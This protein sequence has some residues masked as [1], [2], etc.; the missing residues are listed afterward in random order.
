MR[1]SNP[2]GKENRLC[3][4]TIQQ[5]QENIDR[6]SRQAKADPKRAD[7]PGSTVLSSKPTRNLSQGTV[8]KEMPSTT[9]PL[10]V[11]SGS[12]PS[13]ITVSTPAGDIGYDAANYNAVYD[14]NGNVTGVTPKNTKYTNGYKA[15]QE[16]ATTTD[17]T[18]YG[19][20]G[21]E[22]DMAAYEQKRAAMESRN[23]ELLRQQ[24]LRQQ[25]EA[26]RNAAST[27]AAAAGNAAAARNKGTVNPLTGQTYTGEAGQRLQNRLDQGSFF[28]TPEERDAY[29]I[30]RRAEGVPDDQI[31]S[32]IKDIPIAP[33]STTGAGPTEPAP[34][35]PTTPQ[36]PTT[37]PAAPT[38]PTTPSPRANA[39]QALI[40]GTT[41]PQLKS[42][43]LALQAEDELTGALPPGAEMSQADFYGSKDAS[44]IAKPYDA[45]QTIIDNAQSRLQTGEK[46]MQKFLKDQ[47][48]RNDKYN[49]LQKEN[50][51]NQ[52]MWERDKAVRD[53]ADATKKDLDSRS[54]KLALF[55]GFGS[56]DG[57]REIAEARLKGEEAIIALNKEFGFKKTDVSLQFTQMHNQAVDNYQQR[58]LEVTDQFESRISDLDIQ[59][60]T[61]QQS[62]GEAMKSAYKEYVSG[63]K[64]AR[65]EHAKKISEATSMVYDHMEKEKTAKAAKEDAL[66]DRLFQ[67]RSQ[68]GNLNPTLTNKILS[69][70]QQAGIDTTG[71]DASTMTLAQQNEF[72]RRAKEARD[73][74]NAGKVPLSTQVQQ[75]TEAD[76]AFS[77]LDTADKAIKEFAGVGGP[78]AGM[79]GLGDT[80]PSFL[81]SVG[82]F[83]ADVA[84]GLGI[85]GVASAAER[86]RNANVTFAIVQQ[87]IGKALEG[88]V[89]RKE[90]EVKYSK[91]L[92]NLR[93]TDAL[94][95]SKLKQLRSMMEDGKRA[96]L[97][98]MSRSGYDT[99]GYNADSNGRPYDPL[100]KPENG[101]LTVEEADDILRQVEQ[102]EIDGT[103]VTMQIGDRKVTGL[104][105]AL[106]AL[107]K[108]N[109][110]FFAKTGKHIFVNSSFRTRA[111]QQV[112]WDRYQRGEISR[113]AP[114]GK[115][116]HEHGLAFDITNW[117]EAEPYLIKHGFNPLPADIRDSDPAHFSYGIVG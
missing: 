80:D 51:E 20:W 113:A 24:Q 101:T 33:P 77:L 114:P 11:S 45:I 67:Q 72:Y 2:I 79:T 117:K 41:D 90:D 14:E 112:A 53:Q 63:I 30:A 38:A 109:D 110:E 115:S 32:E 82:K 29:V 66:W 48:D 15:G 108:A 68:D 107:K 100:Y 105:P 21:N 36:A 46:A 71:L 84:T 81:A 22:A 62:K 12:T 26:Q 74:A 3:H 104:D 10:R 73:A 94:R 70:M 1:S 96:L 111:Q 16:P 59:G 102:G 7:L 61:N 57:N 18:F 40:D 31:K 49:A 98:N 58:W 47:F 78:I 89:L 37:P 54:I 39:I 83:G 9:N 25:A 19:Q 69:E 95:A 17:P 103:P 65:K 42:V 60:I 116:L 56:D 97:D 50:I 85:P 8:A 44:A 43:L 64:E 91:L 5:L 52:L 55:G 34:T 23:T 4:Y 106:G 35:T 88:G 75:L 76:K 92:P 28:K 6:N 86:Q 13:T 99:S 87:V 93:D 27:A